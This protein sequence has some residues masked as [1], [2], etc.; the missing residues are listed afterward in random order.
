M[1]IITCNAKHSNANEQ[2]ALNI[3]GQASITFPVG[4]E[5][6]YNGLENK[7]T[8]GW[9]IDATN[10]TTDNPHRGNQCLAINVWGGA[11]QGDFSTIKIMNP[12]DKT[13]KYRLG[14]WVKTDATYLSTASIGYVA[15]N[16]DNHYYANYN[17]ST[18]QQSIAIPA[19]DN[20][21]KYFEVEI[22]VPQ[23]VHDVAQNA[24][25]VWDT[26]LLL[27][28][29]NTDQNYNVWVDDISFSPVDAKIIS[30]NYDNVFNSVTSVAANNTQVAF[31][32][33][34]FDGFGRTKMVTGDDGNVLSMADYHTYDPGISDDKNA[35]KQYGFL[36]PH[37]KA[38][39]LSNFNTFTDADY[40]QTNSYSDGLGRAVQ[41][42]GVRQSPLGYDV[43]SFTDYDANGL[44]PISYLPFTDADVDGS[45]KPSVQS[46]QLNYFSTATA[47]EPT[48]A[49]FMQTV[50]EA[51]PL[52]SVIEAGSY[53]AQWQPGVAASHTA[54]MATGTNTDTE[55]RQ[56]DLA[57]NGAVSSRYWPSGTLFLSEITDEH[58]VPIKIFSDKAGRTICKQSRIF[59]GIDANG[60]PYTYDYTNGTSGGPVSGVQALYETYFV[61]DNMDRL[62]YEIPAKAM[63]EMNGT[64]SFTEGTT[65][66]NEQIKATH[67][68]TRGRISETKNPGTGWKIILYDRF[69]RPAMAQ[70][71]EMAHHNLP[72][73]MYLKYDYYNR[74]VM[75]GIVEL[76][77]LT[78]NIRANLVNTAYPFYETRSTGSGNLMEYT[79]SV[80]PILSNNTNIYAVNYFD[81]YNWNINGHN[82][83]GGI[84]FH[85][86]NNYINGLPTGRKTLTLGAGNF[87]T[88]VAYYDSKLRTIQSYNENHLGGVDVVNMQYDF[89]GKTIR[90]TR[91]HSTSFAS[92]TINYRFEYDR[93][94]R[95]LAAYQQTGTDPE[96]TIDRFAYNESG[97]LITKSLHYDSNGNGPMQQIDYRYNTRGWLTSI[98]NAEL[99]YD[100]VKNMDDNDAF[101][102]ELYYDDVTSF[103]TTT[104]NA[105]I[106]QYNGNIAA[107][108]WKIR[109]PGTD[110]ENRPQHLY[111]YRYDDLGR[112]TAGHYAENSA[113]TPD[114]FDQ[115]LN[116]YRE[117]ANYDFGG[118][119]T[120]LKRQGIHGTMD[121]L[122]YSYLNNGYR[123]AAV[124]DAGNNE[125]FSDGTTATTEYQYNANGNMVQDDNSTMQ[126]AYNAFNMVQQLSKNGQSV[127]Y[128]YDGS[129]QKLS[130]TFNG[131]VHDYIGGI[132][133]VNNVLTYITTAEG[134]VRPR[135]AAAAN[136]TDYV[137]DYFLRDHLG[138]V[139]VVLTEEI[140]SKNYWASMEDEHATEEEALFENVPETR[141]LKPAT[142]PDDATYGTNEKVSRVTYPARPMGHAKLLQLMQGDKVNIATQYYYDLL[143]QTNNNTT[144][145]QVLSQL[146]SALLQAPAGGF[147]TDELQQ[148]SN[149]VTNNTALLNFVNQQ[150]NQPDT[151]GMAKGFLTW[152]FFNREFNFVPE[153]SGSLRAANAGTLDELAALEIAAP[154]NGFMYIYVS[155]NSTQPVNFDNLRIRTIQSAM[156]EENHYYPYGMLIVPLSMQ[157]KNTGLKFQS[158]EWVTA[159][160][161]N[162]YDFNLR[163][164]DPVLARW[165]AADPM[166]QFANPY[167][168]MNGNP[169]STI[170]PTGGSGHAVQSGNV[171]AAEYDVTDYS[172]SYSEQGGPGGGGGGG[173]AWNYDPDLDNPNIGP[174][175]CYDA[176]NN[177]YSYSDMA[178]NTLAHDGLTVR[179]ALQLGAYNTNIQI[180]ASYMQVGERDAVPGAKGGD[181][182]FNGYDVEIDG[183]M[184]SWSPYFDANGNYIGS[185]QG[186][187]E[188]INIGDV[189]NAGLGLVGGLCEMGVGGLSEYVS[190]GATSAVS[191]PLITDGAGRVIAN[192]ARLVEYASGNEKL[193]NALPANLGAA[194]GKAGDMMLGKSLYDYSYGQAFGGAANDVAS[195][196]YGGGSAGPFSDMYSNPTTFNII[197]YGV[198]NT[199][200]IDGIFY[201]FYPLKH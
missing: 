107:V 38:G 70:D 124:E 56:W 188:N 21:W 161:L 3:M 136:A 197:N 77:A 110:P 95:Q 155:N 195:F 69:D 144:T 6:T 175:P 7:Q 26:H 138:N 90:A 76:T 2:V 12:E 142:M 135:N 180:Y 78:D 43:V 20:Q 73:Y 88:S 199:G 133:Y 96:I 41:S 92:L 57:T 80:Y 101:G 87:L 30:Y 11:N 159:M 192:S 18:M 128:T 65:F 100:G 137:Y 99:V 24:P 171:K 25:H 170:D 74:P 52:N 5:A 9:D 129:G 48:T 198:S 154:E 14:A 36:L 167:F 148:I 177:S 81:D 162:M 181:D 183:N 140:D 98:N 42:V 169:V 97:Q 91:N 163:M 178:F 134:R 156:L 33:S 49:P 117:T 194:I 103:T 173:G 105:A 29:N 46:R 109:A 32:Q 189:S 131:Q 120:G 102:E 59:S 71:E 122:R 184:H 114:A 116:R 158:K 115:V 111:T 68:D 190:G 153:A 168:A 125:G 126:V 39:V 151:P 58:G 16:T 196:I 72:Q 62:L 130:K 44:S 22:D 121:K 200:Y 165:H 160:D 34:E 150:L 186:E 113:T 60:K 172:T 66:F 17:Y 85:A 15:I 89:T 82:Y 86:K 132:E 146:A 152:M 54:K 50:F 45:Y 141:E 106:P 157:N 166:A 40:A 174:A 147:T 47:V 75:Y 176:M 145:Q 139:R 23:I 53:G 10:L 104:E 179:E 193:G 79:N 149:S 119:I 182:I 28:V 185:P 27:Y 55:V 84:A 143:Q 112:M 37:D 51:S 61:Y 63:I 83:D 1:L 4:N 123:L 13:R 35:T 67:Y 127:D 164:Y 201:D 191:I 93:L 108:K 118:N 31:A 8:D 94:G 19:T 187:K 64:Y